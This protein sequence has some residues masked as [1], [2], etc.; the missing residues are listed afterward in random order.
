MCA[1]VYRVVD[2]STFD[3][4]PVGRV[5]LVDINA[6]ELNTSMGLGDEKCLNGLN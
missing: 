6:P 4:F 1:N 2:G 3:A 5:R